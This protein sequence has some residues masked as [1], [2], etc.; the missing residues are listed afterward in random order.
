M[1]ESTARTC[2]DCGA[3]LVSGVLTDGDG[4]VERV[5]PNCN[6]DHPLSVAMREHLE[7]RKP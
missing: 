6:P 5:C 3:G 1:S 7:G 2:G 4:T